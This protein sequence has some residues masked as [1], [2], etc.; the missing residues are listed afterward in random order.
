MS[1]PGRPAISPLT[2]FRVIKPNNLGEIWHAQR[3]IALS[4]ANVTS[5]TGLYRG[6][7]LTPFNNSP[8]YGADG[9]YYRG[10]NVVHFN[11]ANSEMLGF[12][13]SSAIGTASDC[14]E[15]IVIARHKTA[16]PYNA[17]VF[18]ALGD[19]GYYN[20]SFSWNV[21]VWH[22]TGAPVVCGMRGSYSIP[23]TAPHMFCNVP[24]LVADNPGV[25]RAYVNHTLVGVYNG[26][27]PETVSTRPVGPIKHYDI[28]GDK[29]SGG[30]NPSDLSIALAIHA[31]N[32]L[33]VAER[34]AIYALAHAE[35]GI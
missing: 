14:G 7:Q 28:G 6:I 20:P 13:L 3:G 22:I 34:T 15:L 10:R 25:V 5:W 29:L 23:T 4:G 11:K 9:S 30:I 27:L 12:S 18:R 32:P 24:N 33:S 31:L 16:I 35:W 21:S 17:L 1:R 2:Y 8:T 26:S 19:A